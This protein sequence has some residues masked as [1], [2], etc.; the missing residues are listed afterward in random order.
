MK[1]LQCRE[2][3]GTFKVIPSRGRPPVKCGGKH[4]LCSRATD[5]VGVGQNGK[6][7]AQQAEEKLKEYYGPEKTAERRTESNSESRK[8]A[9][10]SLAPAMAAKERLEAL[11]WVCKG[12]ARMEDHHALA[13]I[14]ASRGDETVIMHWND[15]Q[16][17]SQNYSLWH[18]KPSANGKPQ[19][20][21]TFDPDECT[22]RELIRAL[23]GSKVT[24]W[25]S[26]G[27]REESAVIGKDRIQIEHC[28]NGV[29]DETPGDRIVKFTEHGGAG[30]RAFKMAA[31]LKVG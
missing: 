6:P 22:D 5:K 8:P 9:N 18:E 28:Y 15:G 27:Q 30:F 14:T 21:L 25:N 11:G 20:A 13:S 7:S 2:H 16:L 19:G 31:L 3:G 1:T 4:E 24:W 12:S 23:A 26:L 10:P 29:G 17:I